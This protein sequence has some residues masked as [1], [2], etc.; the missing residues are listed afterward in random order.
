MSYKQKLQR[1]ANISYVVVIVLFL[2]FFVYLFLF[3]NV[4]VYSGRAERSYTEI[5]D[6]VVEEVKDAAAPAGVRKQYDF[7]IHNVKEG[8]NCLGFYLVHQYADVYFDGELVYSLMPGENNKITKSISSNWIMVPVLSEDEGKAVKIIVTPV[9]KNVIDREPE[10]KLGSYFSIYIEQFKKDL[11]Q[12][13]LAA[14]CILMGIIISAVWAGLALTKKSVSWQIF[15]LGNFSI[16]LGIW[17]LTDTRFSPLMFRSNPLVLGYICIGMLFLGIIPVLL[18]TRSQIGHDNILLPVMTLTASGAGFVLI[19]C[20]IMG[21]AE[22]R[23]LLFIAHI[24]IAVFAVVLMAEMLLTKQE[25]NI[26]KNKISGLYGIIL[27]IGVFADLLKFYYRGNSSGVMYSVCVF[28]IFTIVLFIENLSEINK[29]AYTDAQTGLFNRSRW[30]ELMKKTN[31]INGS[32]GV[33]MFDLNRL[34]YINDTMGHEAGDKMILGFVNILRNC[35]PQ[36][37]TICRWGGDE[38]TVLYLDATKEKVEECLHKIEMAVKEY[39]DSGAKPEIYYAAG[40]ALS[41]ELPGLS[42]LELLKVAD[43]KMYQN[44]QNWYK[45]N[46]R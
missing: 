3:E 46:V 19:I 39:N 8:T 12:L 40:Y 23:Q 11:P 22:F 38:F 27:C 36:S 2:L 43:G 6:Y 28:L 10:F 16:M 41:L 42:G 24:L 21:I 29:K 34:K 30:N 9:Y 18:F 25:N 17:K 26:L 7:T 5:Q 45:E 14:L 31:S 13:M 32:V 33:I 15:Y 20:Q 44:K 35:I 4:S 1:A 37:N